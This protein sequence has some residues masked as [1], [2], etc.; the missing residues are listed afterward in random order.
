MGMHADAEE[1]LLT[2]EQKADP[3]HAAL[4]LVDVQNDFL[5]DGGFFHQVGVDVASMRAALARLPGLLGRARQ[6]G[7]LVGFARAI[8]D[9]E[10]VSGPLLERNRRY[11]L[12][13]SR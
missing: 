7:L 1:L 9:P 2:L 10:Y 5:A 13:A 3:A 4:V 8:Y 11:S 12:E 6:A